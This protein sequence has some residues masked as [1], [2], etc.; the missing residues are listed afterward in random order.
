MSDLMQTIKND[1]FI[2]LPE[3]GD[4][5]VNN[6]PLMK[7]VVP[8]VVIIIAYVLFIIFGQRW[9]K[10]KRPF[11]LR[12]FM[13][14]YNV[15]QV[16]FCT[17]ITYQATYVW[18]KERYS[19]LCQPIDFSE[20][21]TAMI[22]CKA[23]WWF[24]IMKLIDLIDTILFVLRKKDGQI[25]FLHVY[26]HITMTFC[27]WSGSKYVGGG[28]SLFVIIINS[29]IHVLMY[30]YYG[31]SA[32]GPKIQKFLWWKHYITQAQMLQFVAII[33]HSIINLQQQCNFP[34]IFD[35]AFLIYGITILML[36][37]NFYLQNYILKKKRRG[38]EL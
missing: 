3:N 27:G 14:I 4:V 23:C 18:I 17:Y 30:G 7:S 13:F 1:L 9:M 21:P 5:R 12:E 10:N 2:T 38:K 8:T 37:S 29:F 34:K 26:H 15:V 35:V 32:C 24:Y 22:A 33:I 19:F 28:Q 25:T 36:F 6:W 20:S 16:I 11:E 31:L